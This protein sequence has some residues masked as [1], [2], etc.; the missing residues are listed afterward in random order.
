MVG[1]DLEGLGKAI[2]NVG[3]FELP[4]QGQ[5]AHRGASCRLGRVDEGQQ[6]GPF[7]GVLEGGLHVIL[8]EVGAPVDDVHPF[9][10]SD[11]FGLRTD[12]QFRG[13]H[14][15]DDL[16]RCELGVGY[17]VLEAKGAQYVLEVLHLALFPLSQLRPARC[18]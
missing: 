14:R 8:H 2:G 6:L 18:P 17:F 4:V 12:P 1:Q 10:C 9:G 5:D 16:E 3:A 13:F 7:H 15:P 11:G